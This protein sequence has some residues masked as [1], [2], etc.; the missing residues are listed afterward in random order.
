MSRNLPLLGQDD[1]VGFAGESDQVA[2]LLGDING[3]RCKVE[4]RY[5]SSSLQEP[6]PTDGWGCRMIP[7]K[8]RSF[9]IS[10]HDVSL[11]RSR[12][13]GLGL[14]CMVVT[15]GRLGSECSDQNQ[16]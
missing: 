15:A 4:C 9:S 16:H 3:D 1:N 8:F 14:W 2:R 10:I 11:A 5:A 12:R 6:P 7:W 13:G